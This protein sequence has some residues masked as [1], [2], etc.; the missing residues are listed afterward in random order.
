MDYDRDRYKSVARRRSR[1]RSP[2]NSAAKRMIVGSLGSSSSNRHESRHSSSHTHKSSKQKKSK[3]EKK[4]KSKKSKKSKKHRYSSS[5]EDSDSDDISADSDSSTELLMRLEKERL[6]LKKK[7]KEQ[8]DRLKAYETPEEKRARRLLKKQEKRAKDK[9]KMGWDQDYVNYTNEDNPFGDHNLTQNFRWNQK[10]KQEGLDKLDDRELQRIQ[11]VKQ[12]EQRQELEKVKQRRLER[13]RE[14]EERESL[15]ELEER[16]REN[17]KFAKWQKDEDEFHLQQA[18]LRSKIRIEDGRAKPIDL[19]AKYVSTDENEIDTIEMHEPYTYLNGLTIKDLEDLLVDIRV[20][21]EIDLNRNRDFW[22][23]IVTIVDDELRK[24]RKMDRTEYQL[25]ADRRQG[26]NKAVVDDVQKVFQGKSAEQLATLQKGIEMKL[27]A[28]EEGTDIGYWESLL[29]ELKAHLAR[30]RLKDKHRENL[31]NKLEMLRAEQTQEELLYKKD[32]F[33]EKSKELTPKDSPIPSKVS[34]EDEDDTAGGLLHYPKKPT[35][36]DDMENEVTPIDEFIS[37]NYS[38]AY[39]SE[40]D[41]ELGSIIILEDEEIS[42]RKMDQRKALQG[43]KVEN[44]MNA[45]E[46]ALER[47]AKKGMG[48]D[49]AKF[50][51]EA[52]VDPNTSYEWSDKYRPRKPR[53][54]NRVHTGFEWNKY[55]QTHYDI[56]NP[57]PKVVQGYKFN[58]FYPDL[59]DK[60]STPQYTL[61]PCGMEG[62]AKD[63][64]TLRIHAGPPYE[65]IAFKI[66][67][68]EWEFGYKRGFRCQFHNNIFQLWFHF[69]R[70]RYRR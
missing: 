21:E 48:D 60:T 22:S 38:P 62:T 17:D 16:K 10:L 67:N 37:G 15:L 23:D 56:D 26:M 59:I 64:C 55:N 65:D 51:V 58:I 36:E 27:E 6:E 2:N 14:R 8:K 69:K 49:E 43:S 63:F 46:R 9:E 4:S 66:V 61:T 53:Y 30:A 11:R 39:I 52:D 19:L 18:R 3:K 28:K 20:Y 5:S 44:V 50:S 57:P 68:R 32:D 34:T 42:K 1:S 31:T 7:R 25:A 13:E 40:F 24:L 33:D 54:F 29:S 12:E 41:L 47:E 70:L 35:E 45:E